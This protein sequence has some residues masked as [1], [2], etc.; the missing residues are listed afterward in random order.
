MSTTTAKFNNS[1]GS[2]SD[3]I[4]FADSENLLSDESDI[5]SISNFGDEHYFLDYMN[6]SENLNAFAKENDIK[7]TFVSEKKNSI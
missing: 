5:D 3:A 1:L 7:F 6:T 4:C 2:S